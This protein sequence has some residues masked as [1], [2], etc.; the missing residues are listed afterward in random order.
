MATLKEMREQ[1][2]RTQAD[3]ASE[4]GISREYLSSLEN[5]LR[6][7]R[8]LAERLAAIYG[9]PVA[10]V[11]GYYAEEG[12]RELREDTAAGYGSITRIREEHERELQVRDREIDALRAQVDAL[13]QEAS[14]LR[15]QLEDALHTRDFAQDT[16]RMLL[17]QNS[18]EDTGTDGE[19]R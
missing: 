9:R 3:V 18:R 16:V 6:P 8:K 7:S 10:E 19:N 17:K 14:S 2:G 12:A 1:T 4:A 11:L 15:V 5:G 13:Q